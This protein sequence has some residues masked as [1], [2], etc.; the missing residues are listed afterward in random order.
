MRD[1]CVV[2]K[3]LPNVFAQTRNC[4]DSQANKSSTELKEEWCF[5][6]CLLTPDACP[7]AQI[8]IDIFFTDDIFLNREINSSQKER[9][10]SCYQIFYL[11]SYTSERRMFVQNISYDCNHIWKISRSR[12]IF[13]IPFCLPSFGNIQRNEMFSGTQHYLIIMEL[14]L[15][16]IQKNKSMYM[17]FLYWF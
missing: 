6:S 8:D 10:S 1:L 15:S 4:S 11:L 5:L 2:C 14:S 12:P 16:V 7:L 3:S 13:S 9:F 17:S